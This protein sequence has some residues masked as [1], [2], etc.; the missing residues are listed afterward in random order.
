V[1]IEERDPAE[2]VQ[3]E[4]L[5]NHPTLR[6]VNPQFDVT[7]PEYIDVLVTERGLIP[8]GGVYGLMNQLFSK[9][10]KYFGSS[11]T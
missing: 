1:K 8:P 3:R 6:I 10:G 4:L 11:T 7:P 2:I 5:G 9:Q